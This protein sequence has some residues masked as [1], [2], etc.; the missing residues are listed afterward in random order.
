MMG[1]N[2]KRRQGLTMTTITRYLRCWV[3]VLFIGGLLSGTAQAA[4]S[5]QDLVKQTSQRMLKALRDEQAHIKESPERLHK[6]VDEI[7]L[8]H[9]DFRRMSRLVLGRYWRRASDRQQE[10]FVDE[11]RTLLVRTYTSALSQY[12]DQTIRYLPFNGDPSRGDVTVR[13][14]VQRTGG[15]P[16]PIDYSLMH[17]DGEWKVYDVTIAG[18][19]LVINYRSSFANE[20]HHAGL[21]GLID[22]LHDRNQKNRDG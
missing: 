8:P 5:P 2:E 6:L 14:E 20:I 21:D 1:F 7:V 17:E 4:V 13:T 16:I 9:F 11:F 10:R 22:K 18:V 3:S 19:S 12:T 15:S